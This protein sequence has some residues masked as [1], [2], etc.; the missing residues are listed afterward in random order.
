VPES[1]VLNRIDQYEDSRYIKSNRRE[2][3]VQTEVA[4][5]GPLFHATIDH[6]SGE[7]ARVTTVTAFAAPDCS[8]KKL[9]TDDPAR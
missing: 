3:G 5:N 4:N 7:R 6:M 8:N 9:R 1:A 2:P